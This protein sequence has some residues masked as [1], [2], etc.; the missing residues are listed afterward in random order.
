MDVLHAHNGHTPDEETDLIWEAT[1]HGE[2]DD[3]P[4]EVPLRISPVDCRCVPKPADDQRHS[5][6]CRFQ[7]SE[8]R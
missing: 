2:L 6:A 8:G 5:P 7:N 4:E 1:V 3:Q